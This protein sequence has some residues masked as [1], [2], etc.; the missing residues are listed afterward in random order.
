MKRQTAL[1]AIATAFSVTVAS[2]GPVT[3]GTVSNVVIAQATDAG[4]SVEPVIRHHRRTT[5]ITV[6]PTARFYR[7]CTDWYELQHRPSGDV[8]YP[9]MRCRWVAR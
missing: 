3:A 9:Q 7:E 5:R 6:Y 8:I 1:T 2:L 4:P